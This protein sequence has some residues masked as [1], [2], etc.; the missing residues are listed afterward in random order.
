MEF[1]SVW[2][3]ELD[4]AHLHLDRIFVT[5]LNFCFSLYSIYIQH[6][7]LCSIVLYIVLYYIVCIL[8]YYLHLYYACCTTCI[9]SCNEWTHQPATLGF[10]ALSLGEWAHSLSISL[11]LSFSLCLSARLCVVYINVCVCVCLSSL[12]RFKHLDHFFSA[13]RFLSSSEISK[14]R[15]ARR[16]RKNTVTRLYEFVL[17]FIRCSFWLKKD[18]CWSTL[19]ERTSI[20]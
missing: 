8:L 13:G 5:G 12:F 19:L 20:V 14:R 15:R 11:F 4:H 7:I 1:L 10:G 16:K 2:I 6:F 18:I 9:V 3:L 17:Y